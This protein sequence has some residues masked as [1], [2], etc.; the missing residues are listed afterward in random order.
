MT[1]VSYCPQD[2]SAAKNNPNIRRSFENDIKKQGGTFI[3]K[4]VKAPGIDV[5][6][7]TKDG[8]ET[9]IEVWTEDNGNYNYVV[10]R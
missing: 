5:Y 2:E 1:Q 3:G 7:L 4:T 9:W 6:R 8:K 10:T